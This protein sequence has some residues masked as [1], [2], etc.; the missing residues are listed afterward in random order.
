MIEEKIVEL[1]A[2]F[3][4]HLP[5]AP[6][7]TDP[8]YLTYQVISES[9]Q[10]TIGG[11]AETLINIQLNSY[12]LTLYDAKRT[13]KRAVGVLSPLSPFRINYMQ[14]YDSEARLHCALVEFYIFG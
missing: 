11:T 2:G 1:L 5:P 14:D 10:D 4:V 7:G 9:P 13:V 3:P 6:A 12:A 8:P